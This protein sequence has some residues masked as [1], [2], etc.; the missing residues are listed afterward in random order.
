MK[1]NQLILR[2]DLLYYCHQY[3]REYNDKKYY[4]DVS[5]Y[6][7]DKLLNTHSNSTYILFYIYRFINKKFK[8]YIR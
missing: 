5:K 4:C 6:F 2:Q 1:D 7:K 3:T 8:L